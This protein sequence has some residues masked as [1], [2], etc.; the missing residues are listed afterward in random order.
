VDAGTW[1]R[2]FELMGLQR[3]IKVLGI[4]C[5][6]WYRDGKRGYLADLPRVWNYVRSVGAQHPEFTDFITLVESKINGRD[7]TQPAP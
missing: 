6:L 3:H 5:R 1:Q 4:F 2:W 7:L